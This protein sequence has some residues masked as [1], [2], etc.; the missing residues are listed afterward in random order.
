MEQHGRLTPATRP[1]KGDEEDKEEEKKRKEKRKNR[2][3]RKKKKKRKI[4]WK[5][6]F[7]NGK[8][9]SRERGRRRS[10]RLLFFASAAVLFACLV[11]AFSTLCLAFAISIPVPDFS[12]SFSSDFGAPLRCL[13]FSVAVRL[14]CQCIHCSSLPPIDFMDGEMCF[15]ASLCSSVRRVVLQLLAF[16]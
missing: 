1:R 14:R 11:S 8:T 2:K 13:F 16:S 6:K 10:L 9:R 3:G 15:S 12:S 4:K 7:K 5:K